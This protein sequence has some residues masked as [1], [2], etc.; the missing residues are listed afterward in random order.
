M[1]ESE[2]IKTTSTSFKMC[3]IIRLAIPAA[4]SLLIAKWIEVINLRAIGHLKTDDKQYMI[5]GVG[6]GNMVSNIIGL[7]FIYGLNMTL[8]TLVSQASGGKNLELCGIYLNRGRVLLTILF[9]PISGILFNIEPALLA[10]NQ[11]P[12]VS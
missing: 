11:D 8:E 4:I 5:G 6:L 7:S 3:Q 10:L 12:K 2:D 9:L 1:S